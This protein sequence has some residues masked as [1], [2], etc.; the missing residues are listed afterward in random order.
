MTLNG[1]GNAA[2]LRG[3][4]EKGLVER[5]WTI[6]IAKGDGD[7]QTLVAGKD[8]RRLILLLKPEGDGIE[9]KL[10]TFPLPAG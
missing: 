5:G 9:A 1:K 4:Y 8:S 2:A 10:S 6:D 3:A 7:L